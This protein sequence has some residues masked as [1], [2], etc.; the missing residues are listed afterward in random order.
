MIQ[1]TQGHLG[2]KWTVSYNFFIGSLDL[3]ET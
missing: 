2:G 3:V 1:L